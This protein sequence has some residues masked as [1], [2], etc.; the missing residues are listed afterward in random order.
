ME[1]FTTLSKLT[2]GCVGNIWDLGG[3]VTQLLSQKSS[4]DKFVQ[5]GE[6][7]LGRLK[8]GGAGDWG[9]LVLFFVF[10]PGE[11]DA[12]NFLLLPFKWPSPCHWSCPEVLAFPS[13][14]GCL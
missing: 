9:K 8:A 10:S 7:L 12:V 4:R 1:F 2:G 14:R 13:S 11:S 5:D 3:P 6:F